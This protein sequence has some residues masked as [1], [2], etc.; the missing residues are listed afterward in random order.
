MEK[1]ALEPD[2][3][4]TIAKDNISYIRGYLRTANRQPIVVKRQDF[5]NYQLKEVQNCI[6]QSINSA[7]LTAEFQHSHFLAIL[8]VHLE[9]QLDVCSVYHVFEALESDVMRYLER[10]RAQIYYSERELSEYLLR[11]SDVL[12][13]LHNKVCQI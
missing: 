4:F 7:L 9:F 1:Y 8:G 10:K 12:V 5:A 11:I 2:P 3:Y 6:D 13:C